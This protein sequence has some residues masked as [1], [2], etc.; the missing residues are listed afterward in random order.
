[1]ERSPTTQ[2]IS[3]FLDLNRWKQLDLEP[4]YQRRSVWTKKDKQFF[5]DTIFRQFPS[6]A[7]YLHKTIDDRGEATFHVVDG[8]QRLETI[9]CFYNNKIR[10]A[11]NYG[12]I[13][14]DN[15]NW[16]DVQKDVDL[17]NSFLN[18]RLPV[19]MMDIVD[20]DVVNSVFDRLNRNSKKLTPQELR[21]ARYDGW[22]TQFVEN[23]I[24]RPEWVD[25][26]VV[27]LARSR[28]MADSQFLSEL[29]AIVLENDFTGFDQSELDR[30]YAKYD[31]EPSESFL[32][33]LD[34]FLRDFNRIKGTLC[35]IRNSSQAIQKF[36][37]TLA[38][39]Y[40]L[41]CFIA[42]EPSEIDPTETAGKLES[43]AES[44]VAASQPNGLVNAIRTTQQNSTDHS[45]SYWRAMIG[46]STDYTP[47]AERLDI[48]RQVLNT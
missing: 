33:S 38:N 45:I 30:Y 20:A 10:L 6:P 23:E 13:R 19:E 25:L 34:D 15:K 21:H 5:L 39:L 31:E 7:I 48:L 14:L 9:L 27:T 32:F 16:K 24:E 43:F 29:V 28:R 36:C 40:T 26:G 11:R 18:Y 1:M 2:D 17:R 47:R 35:C 3:W 42:L 12:D 22:F 41:W 8:K 37:E 4:P 46:A 44:V